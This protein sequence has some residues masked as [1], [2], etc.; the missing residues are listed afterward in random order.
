M[1]QIL[2]FLL[3]ISFCE[4][5]QAQGT[6]L[7]QGSYD[8]D[9]IDRLSIKS[10]IEP[11]F[12][13]SIRPYLRGDVVRYAMQVDTGQVSISSKDRMDLYWIFKNSNEWLLCADQP[14][15]VFGSRESVYV[16]AFQDSVGTTFYTKNTQ[17]QACEKDSRYIEKEPFL[18]YL[19]RTPANL[20]ELNKKSFFFRV[21]PMLD[22]KIFNQFGDDNDGLLFLNKRGLEIRAGIDDRVFIYT[23]LVE[24]QGRF[25]DYVNNYRR[26]FQTHPKAG[27]LKNFRSTIFDFDNGID[28]NYANAIVGFNVS[29]HIGVQFGHGSNFIGN[30][31]RSLILSDFGANYLHLKINWKIW[32]FHYQNI[33][34]ELNAT[35]PNAD[36]GDIITPKKYLAAHYLTMNLW[37]GATFG[38]YEATVFARDENEQFEL[39]YLNPVI[40]YRSVEQ[41]IGSPDNVLIGANFSWTMW[42]RYQLYGQ[43]M[44][45]EFNLGQGFGWWANKFGVQ[46]GVKYVDALGIDHLDIQ[47]EF[48][49]L[50]P[51]TFSHRDTL[52]ASYSHNNQVLAHP[53]GANFS[54][55]IVK[56][57]YQPAKKWVIEG[58][59]IR[60][61][62][63]E[64]DE[65]R[66]HWGG[67]ILTPT[68]PDEIPL[69]NDNSIGQ[70]VATNTTILGLDISYQFRHNL[71][72][73]VEFFHRMQESEL[74][75]RDDTDTYFGGGVR[76]NIGRNR[77]DF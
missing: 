3:L 22:F 23:N 67:N 18:K 27:L 56:G 37:K 29:K 55:I 28:W 40:L 45:D 13:P 16:P 70:G 43:I 62:Y 24:A 19:Y 15:T 61:N 6:I 10:G 58:R 25:S 4:C 74:D 9:L 52:G 63:G 57:R 46:A 66:N 76:W 38:F 64:D 32:K 73:E 42:K 11:E 1:K 59:L 54:E 75:S 21:N 39:Q 60:A 7:P 69:I 5:A 72:L 20:F 44:V 53:L 30:G 41:L 48:N 34:A 33:F 31:Y 35:S 26:L 65:E 47:A 17:I 36:V 14:T 68:R 49:T 12:H 77:L 8:Y 2:L 71:F 50:R 51:Y